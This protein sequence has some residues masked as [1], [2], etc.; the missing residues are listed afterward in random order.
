MNGNDKFTIMTTQFHAIV[1]IMP[2][3]AVIQIKRSEVT[4]EV[5]ALAELTGVSITDAI[6]IAVKR[7]LEIE[8]AKAD[9]RLAKRRKEVN[10]LLGEIRSAFARSI[11]NWCLTAMPIASV[12]D[13]PVRAARART[14][15]VTSE[16]LI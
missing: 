6:G 12:I 9:L 13:T 4:E 5:R 10:K 3:A 2:S 16:R 15:S 14:S 1:V 8:R 11:S 7:Q